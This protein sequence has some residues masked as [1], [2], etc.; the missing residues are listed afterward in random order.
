MVL[1]TPQRDKYA[2]LGVKITNKGRMN[3]HEMIENNRNMY[4]C[5]KKQN[6]KMKC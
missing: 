6:P 4:L 3:N 1:G 5:Y 2:Y